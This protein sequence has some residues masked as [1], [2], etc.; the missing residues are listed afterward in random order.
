LNDLAELGPQFQFA[1]GIQID[2]SR[3]ACPLLRAAFQAHVA[4]AVQI[5]MEDPGP[6]GP[7]LI[8]PTDRTLHSALD[9]TVLHQDQTFQEE[10]PLIPFQPSG[11]LVGIKNDR[12]GIAGDVLRQADDVLGQS[13]SQGHSDKSQKR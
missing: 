1:S 10:N 13:A 8:D 5:Q 2:E 6:F 9:Q 11:N 12:F 7:F 3:L 4:L